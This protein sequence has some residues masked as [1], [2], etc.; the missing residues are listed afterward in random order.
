[1]TRILHHP[2]P[3][4]ARLTRPVDVAARYPAPDLAL[5]TGG[6]RALNALTR[7]YPTVR[8]L[9]GIAAEVLFDLHA[10]DV[11]IGDF[12]AARALL[13]VPMNDP[14]EH[15]KPIAAL[16]AEA[17]AVMSARHAEQRALSAEAMR[18]RDQIAA[19]TWVDAA[20]GGEMTETAQ[21][22]AS[23]ASPMLTA[24]ASLTNA[25]ADLDELL[26][27]PLP[28]TRWQLDLLAVLPTDVVARMK[29]WVA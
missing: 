2:I 24:G 8:P 29:G 15:P 26:A 1:M 25:L 18:R 11:R 5:S 20:I 9:P 7:P 12:A 28:G 19:A 4:E 13:A 21:G 10:E 23:V 27:P 3:D 16:L 6:Q 17:D 22:V 14:A